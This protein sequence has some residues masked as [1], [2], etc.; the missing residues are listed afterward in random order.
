MSELNSQWAEYYL[1]RGWYVLPVHS[2][3]NVKC[4]CRK[5]NC[6]DEGKHPMTRSGVK[7]ATIDLSESKQWWLKWPNANVAIAT[8]IK[9]GIVV[10]DIDP[11]NGGDET[12][13]KLIKDIG[14]LPST[15]VA[16]TGGGGQHY[17]FKYPDVDI[18]G[19]NNKLGVGIDVKS[20]GGYVVATPSVHVS[21]GLYRWKNGCGPDEI[22]LAEL[23]DNI[24]KRLVGET[25]NLVKV[26]AVP[27]VINKG[28][29]NSFLF[30]EACSLRSKGHSRRNIETLLCQLNVT[31]CN[32]P[33]DD[34]EVFKIIVSASKYK[35]GETLPLYIWRDCVRSVLGPCGS[36]GS[37]MRHILVDLSFYMDGNGNN[38]YPT[39][40]TIASE[41]MYSVAHVSKILTLAE[42]EGWIRKE[43]HKGKGQAW[44]N[45]VYKPSLPPDVLRS[46]QHVIKMFCSD[47]LKVLSS[48]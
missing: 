21:G 29:R 4:S 31:I 26:D 32:P 18:K 17:Y 6:G 14:Q 3:E 46:E 39:Q 15:V 44:R 25:A 45:I 28:Q 24:V 22:D 37:S 1:S 40:E 13:A 8:G 5:I 10:L 41:T 9:S 7:D 19:G 2:V 36:H 11:R 43:S 38:C 35:K 16:D 48:E 34:S 12:L 47:A 30:H 23:P 20:D 33:L 27:D 42:K